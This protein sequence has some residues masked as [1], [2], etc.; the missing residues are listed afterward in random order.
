MSWLAPR[1]KQ[2][3]HWRYT[4]RRCAGEHPF[5]VT[6]RL[7]DEVLAVAAEW[8]PSDPSRRLRRLSIKKTGRALEEL[9]ASLQQR[10]E[11][12]ERITPELQRH[13]SSDVDQ[14]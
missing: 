13:L 12:P 7:H 10:L 4:N 8:D 14:L 3:L 6:A 2:E 11:A 9:E 1:Q 5:A